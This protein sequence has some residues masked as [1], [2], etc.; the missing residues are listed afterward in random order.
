MHI[1]VN[2]LLCNIHKLT[3]MGANG[4]WKGHDKRRYHAG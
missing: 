4:R 1:I 2:I 3:E